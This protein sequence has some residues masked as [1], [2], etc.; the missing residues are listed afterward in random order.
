MVAACRAIKSKGLARNALTGLLFVLTIY[1]VFS[2][3]LA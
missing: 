1:K 3:V 2:Y